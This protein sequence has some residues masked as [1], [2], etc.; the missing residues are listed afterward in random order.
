MCAWS[1]PYSAYLQGAYAQLRGDFYEANQ[2]FTQVDDTW[3][4]LDRKFNIALSAGEI[5]KAA[6]IAKRMLTADNGEGIGAIAQLVL[7]AHAAREG[8]WHK[9]DT[10]LVTAQEESPE[11]IYFQLLRNFVAMES[12]KSLDDIIKNHE[13]QDVH[14]M[15]LSQHQYHLGRLYALQNNTSSARKALLTAYGL[16]NGTLLATAALGDMYMRLGE[17][18]NARNTYASFMARNPGVL[19]FNK[20]LAHAIEQEYTPSSRYASP[21][22]DQLGSEVVFNFAM[23]IWAQGLDIPARQLLNLAMWMDNDQ[24]FYHYYAGLM[25]ETE[26]R[27][28]QAL[29]RYTETLPSSPAWLAMQVRVIDIYRQRGNYEAATKLAQKLTKKYP[30]H[31]L[32]QQLLAEIYY[33]NHNFK[34]ALPHFNALIADI[35]TPHAR[36]AAWYFARGAS[37]ERLKQ[38]KDAE[39]DLK[40]ALKLDPQ[41]A[42]IMN[43][44]GYMW[45]EQ[46]IH[47][48]K[49]LELLNQALALSPSDAAILD[50]LGW[51]YYKNNDIEKAAH[52]IE[53]AYTLD[54]NDPI[55]TE[56][57]GDMHEKQGNLSLAKEYWQRAAAMV[58]D[59]TE[60]LSRINK[61]LNKGKSLF[62]RK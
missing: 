39:F 7:A 53:K 55:I 20:A 27:E 46:D 6:A 42:K 45:V 19:L 40:Q 56:H 54:A 14:M 30:Q 13:S 5:D 26:G 24:S 49:A 43:Y 2:A 34:A 1:A 41:N 23:M 29:A 35:E 48:D 38:Y 28:D 10:Y 8:A 62:G 50:S 3:I 25:D 59:D 57:M 61:K 51:A 33:E 44:L 36:H 52:Y 60:S 47:L 15:F 18:Q 37:Y 16:D 22:F 9:A 58:E 12:G 17:W 31:S 21:S 4:S 32:M 11:V